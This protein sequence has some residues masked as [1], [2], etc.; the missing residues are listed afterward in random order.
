MGHNY[1][2]FKMKVFKG[3]HD[4]KKT[5]NGP[6]WGD[7]QNFGA[8]VLDVPHGESKLA[9]NSILIAEWTQCHVCSLPRYNWAGFWA[10]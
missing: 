5:V 7:P 3:F 1:N 4:G 2:P 8:I 6:F 10:T 9:L